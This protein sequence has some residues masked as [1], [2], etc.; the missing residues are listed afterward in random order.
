MIVALFSDTKLLGED[1]SYCRRQTSNGEK[2]LITS[3]VRRKCQ[4]FAIVMVLESEDRCGFLMEPR[5]KSPQNRRHE[6]GFV[7]VCA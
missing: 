2:G 4:V 1:G 7:N 5:L 3:T 6:S